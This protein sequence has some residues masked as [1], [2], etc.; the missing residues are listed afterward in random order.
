MNCRQAEKLL[1]LWRDGRLGEKRAGPLR[2]H[3]NTCKHCQR[4][5]AKWEEVVTVLREM[6]A[7]L[8]PE[9]DFSAQVRAKITEKVVRQA[10][11][12]AR[13]RIWNWKKAVATAAVVLLALASAWGIISG[14]SLPQNPPSVA[15]ENPSYVP[16]PGEENL[17][18][19]PLG[20]NKA[21]PEVQENPGEKP[22][23]AEK[24]PLAPPGRP[25]AGQEVLQVA[26]EKEGSLENEKGSLG[27]DKPK[28]LE[29]GTRVFLNKERNLVSTLL[30]VTTSEVAAAAAKAQDF[31]REA[32]AKAQ[33]IPLGNEEEQIVLRFVVPHSQAEKLR[34]QLEALGRV[35][36]QKTERKDVTR[37]FAVKQE[38]YQA[39]K[40]QESTVGSKERAY[41]EA[42]IASLEAQLQ[43]LETES[44]E[45][46]KEIVTLWLK[47]PS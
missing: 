31:A 19:P 42:Q 15:L 38:E 9:A 32:G 7:L 18:P 37:E 39:L 14:G 17:S 3:V 8:V 16:L 24:E 26:L 40:A 4:E 47:A 35:T 22:P 41:L 20:P 5:L 30:E 46:G 45:A 28:A 25:E 21:V 10:L 1:F 12:L 44:I 33:V 23:E 34:S 43:A 6:N 36:Y 27:Q 11:P 2:A 29:E 13:P